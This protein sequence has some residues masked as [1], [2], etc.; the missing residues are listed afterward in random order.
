M[1][2][3]GVNIRIKPKKTETPIPITA[4]ENIVNRPTTFKKNPPLHF[5]YKTNKGAEVIL[6]LVKN[7][8]DNFVYAVEYV[9]NGISQ[10]DYLYYWRK[11]SPSQRRLNDIT[12]IKQDMR[13]ADTFTATRSKSY[14]STYSHIEEMLQNLGVDIEETF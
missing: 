11:Q 2:K 1:T 9:L 14:G 12:N 3:E 10:F 13:W 8:E 5:V 6:R 4:W 7:N